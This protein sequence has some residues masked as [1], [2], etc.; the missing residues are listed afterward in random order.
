M[1]VLR[2]WMLLSIK[3]IMSASANGSSNSLDFMRRWIALEW[4][5][6][7]DAS[8]LLPSSDDGESIS[9]S[10]VGHDGS[11]DCGDSGA[12]LRRFLVQRL[13]SGYGSFCP[14]DCAARGGLR[15]FEDELL[16]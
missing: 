10:V 14:W 1:A 16:G 11:V 8:E 9:T 13:N 12:A 2:S 3:L 7:M 6:R 15:E 5:S 4:L